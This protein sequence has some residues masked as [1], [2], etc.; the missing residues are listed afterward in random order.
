[1]CSRMDC[2]NCSG[3]EHAVPLSKGAD[4]RPFKY[5]TAERIVAFRE[6]LS[7]F[8]SRKL[9]MAFVPVGLGLKNPGGLDHL[10]VV[11]RTPDELNP[12]RQSDVIKAARH[13]DRRQSTDVADATNGVGESQRFVQIRIDPG[14]GHG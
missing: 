7:L 3:A 5:G 13:T 1:M 14:S 2:R 11:Q 9:R 8:C 10:C 6:S 4:I 12:D